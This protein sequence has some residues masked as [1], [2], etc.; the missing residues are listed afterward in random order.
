M[1]YD[2]II[3]FLNLRAKT[4]NDCHFEMEVVAFKMYSLC[5]TTITNLTN[6]EKILQTKMGSLK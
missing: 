6:L 1:S 2:N 5:P 3:T 4:L